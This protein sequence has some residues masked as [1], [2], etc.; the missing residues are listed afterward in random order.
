[1]FQVD[2]NRISSNTAVVSSTTLSLSLSITLNQQSIHNTTPSLGSPHTLVLTGLSVSQSEMRVAVKK[3]QEKGQ[4]ELAEAFDQAR[5]TGLLCMSTPQ[6]R[7][8]KKAPYHA[9]SQQQ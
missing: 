8:Q 1:M 2:V 7:W 6:T 3:L 9:N 4:Q 5:P